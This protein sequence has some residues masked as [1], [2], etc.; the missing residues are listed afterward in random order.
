[1]TRCFVFLA[2]IMLSASLGGA[3]LADSP[4]STLT[5]KM[6]VFNYLLGTAW[7]CDSRTLDTN[8]KVV[9]TTKS[10]V[11]FDTAPSNTLH[12]HVLSDK[13]ST[14]QYIGYVADVDGYWSTLSNSAGISMLQTSSDGK[15][16]DG[17]T[18]LG[19]TKVYLST[20]YTKVDDS[21]ASVKMISTINGRQEESDGTCSR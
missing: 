18:T 7:Q 21:H 13:V 4:P 15:N 20:T 19:S 1:M 9:R 5:G 17:S 2:T 6:A 3:A 10:T 11:M 16:F 8:G 12:F 14:D